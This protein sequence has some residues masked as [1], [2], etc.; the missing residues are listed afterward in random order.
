MATVRLYCEYVPFFVM[1][2]THKKKKLQ[3]FKNRV[4]H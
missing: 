2:I 1:H 4:A 3:K